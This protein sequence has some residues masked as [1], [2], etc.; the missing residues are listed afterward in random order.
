MSGVVWMWWALLSIYTFPEA[1]S[2]QLESSEYCECL[3]AVAN[4]LNIVANE[5]NV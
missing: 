2:A 1:E 5:Q 4:D 3:Y